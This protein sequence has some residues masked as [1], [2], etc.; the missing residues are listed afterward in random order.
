MQII[1][2]N[3]V[4]ESDDSARL[5]GNAT[6]P[7]LGTLLDTF[8]GMSVA[9]NTNTDWSRLPHFDWATVDR[10]AEAIAIICT[11]AE[12][13]RT[14]EATASE[15]RTLLVV[16]GSHDDQVKGFRQVPLVSGDHCLQCYHRD[17]LYIVDTHVQMGRQSSADGA[18][19]LSIIVAAIA[20]EG[21]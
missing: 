16:V 17:G 18:Q 20:F 13:L 7:E 1:Q 19:R 4:D 3:A 10:F 21:S 8:R 15:V 9:P 12:H 2:T 6:H 14:R 5:I 11:V